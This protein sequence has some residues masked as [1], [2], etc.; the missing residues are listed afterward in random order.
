MPRYQNLDPENSLRSIGNLLRWKLRMGPAVSPPTPRRAEVPFVRNDGSALRDAP[1]A[2]LTWV[3]HA[4]YLCQLAG[5]SVLTDPILS[6][7]MATIVRNVAPGLTHETLPRI[8]VVTVSHNHRDHMDAPT[9]H[10]LG[11]SVAFVVPKGL[12]GWFLRNGLRNVTELDWWETTEVCGLAVTFVPAQHWSRRGLLDENESLWGGFVIAGDGKRDY[13]SGDTAY[14]SGFGEIGRRAGPIDAA[15]LPIGAYEP[16]WFMQAQHMNPQDAVQAFQ[17]LGAARFF[18]MHWGTFKLTDEA[19]DEPP[20]VV[21]AL[22]E[23]QARDP[24]RLVIPAV[25]ET[26]LL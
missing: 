12:G 22:W 4:T 15:M 3:G 16:R 18:A 14:F 24:A 23:E 19:L 21:R 1:R 9:L 11:P 7:R 13:H 6:T 5:R 25:G 10:R 20:A 26:V 2:S 17:D 8:D